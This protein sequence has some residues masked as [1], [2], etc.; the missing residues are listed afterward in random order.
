MKANSK[1]LIITKVFIFTA[2]FI[3]SFPFISYMNR[4][5]LAHT[6]KIRAGFY[7]L[8]KNTLD[9]CFIGTSGTFSAFC[10][11][12]AWKSYGF[13]SYNFCSNQMC[14]DNYIYAIDEI[15]KTQNPKV[16]VIDVYPFIAHERLGDIKNNDSEYT[17]RFNTDGYRYS[18]NRFKLIYNAVPRTWNKIP[19]YFDILYYH[20]IKLNFSHFNF[21]SPD[22]RK[23]YSNLS[24]GFWEPALMTDKIKPLE[25]DFDS[26]LNTLIEHCKKKNV[27]F[28]FIYY[29]Y[30]NTRE[31]S[32]EYVNYIQNKV[33]EN[34]FPFI[35]CENFID[36]FNFNSTLDFWDVRHWNIFGAE[37]VTKV[38]TR[39]FLE[40]YNF[41]DKR[42][43]DSFASWNEDI[44]AWDEY[45]K[46]E[47]ATILKQKE[48]KLQQSL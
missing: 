24:W 26:D 44:K 40:L 13:T 10:P 32:I 45:V 14:T 27:N 9:A 29:P 19:F 43:D 15:L 38:F 11:M 35:N 34:G 37:K 1:A 47:K 30:G 23:G 46:A 3:F 7:A 8:K 5:D 41:E 12:E 33:K 17:I 4:R 28:L 39:H 31:D 16:I 48:E 20:D 21:A 6:T 2:L 25:D 18:L 22:F 42:T 36:E